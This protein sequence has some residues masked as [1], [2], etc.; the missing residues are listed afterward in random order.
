[1]F[2]PLD[3]VPRPENGSTATPPP[4]AWRALCA[5]IL[6]VLAILVAVGIGG[7]TG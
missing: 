5:L 1:M 7:G 2:A 3:V 6:I 4:K